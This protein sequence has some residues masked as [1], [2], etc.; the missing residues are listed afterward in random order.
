MRYDSGNIKTTITS[1]WLT[2]TTLKPNDKFVN[3]VLFNLNGDRAL[4]YTYHRE[5]LR[6]LNGMYFLVNATA[7]FG[8]S[9]GY[10]R[11]VGSTLQMRSTGDS[12][13][14]YFLRSLQLY[15]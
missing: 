14:T 15:G 13:H 1:N 11:L 4:N 7:S 6:A 5:Q 3:I 9:G 2:I 8:Y 12:S 10:I